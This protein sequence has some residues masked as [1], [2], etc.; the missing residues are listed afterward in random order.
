M[1]M[2]VLALIVI[3]ALTFTAGLFYWLKY[4]DKGLLTSLITCKK[5]KMLPL[6]AKP[7]I[8]KFTVSCLRSFTKFKFFMKIMNMISKLTGTPNLHLNVN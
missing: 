3:S 8:K 7:N 6:I 1:E 5:F 4:I 2:L